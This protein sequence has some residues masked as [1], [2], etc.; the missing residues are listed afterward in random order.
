[1]FTVNYPLTIII[2]VQVEVEQITHLKCNKY[3]KYVGKRKKVT[4]E[5]KGTDNPGQPH[6]YYQRD[7]GLEP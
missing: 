2:I 5:K 6:D 7:G 4:I 3:G 1:M